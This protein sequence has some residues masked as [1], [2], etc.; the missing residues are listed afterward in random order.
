M[1]RVLLAP[2]AVLFE[3]E[4]AL[5]TPD[6][7]VRPVVIALA[8]RALEAD[9]IWLRHKE[10]IINTQTRMPKKF[11]MHNTRCASWLFVIG[12]WIFF[13]Y[14]GLR[15]GSYQNI[16]AK[17]A[18]FYHPYSLSAVGSPERDRACAPTTTASAA[19]RIFLIRYCPSSVGAKTPCQVI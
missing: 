15:I 5:G 2:R 14:S 16:V 1:R 11:P 9:E 12:A 4:R 3:R 17:T 8:G 13:R 19:I 10:K 18:T 6:V 7:F